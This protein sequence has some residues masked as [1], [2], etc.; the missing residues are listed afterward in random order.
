M[1]FHWDKHARR[2]QGINQPI[3]AKSLVAVTKKMRQSQIL[4][5]IYLQANKNVTWADT[6]PDMQ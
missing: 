5:A 2:L 3:Q 4:F 6:N 1:E